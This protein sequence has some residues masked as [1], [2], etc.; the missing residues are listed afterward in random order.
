M[1][2]VGRQ[3]RAEREV[4]FIETAECMGA[5]SGVIAWSA[6]RIDEVTRRAG[7]APRSLFEK[8]R[9]YGLRKDALRQSPRRVEGSPTR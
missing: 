7:M 3:P 9:R 4:L 1:D 8:M 2:G 6:G 5:P